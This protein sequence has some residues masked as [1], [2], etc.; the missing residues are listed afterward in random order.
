[1]P[2]CSKLHLEPSGRETK[3]GCDTLLRNV[4]K[5]KGAGKEVTT[6]IPSQ[7]RH[8]KPTVNYLFPPVIVDTTGVKL[9]NSLHGLARETKA[10]L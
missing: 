8:A 10:A 1:M 6:Q 3:K 4:Y 2:D 7:K 9:L 5:Y